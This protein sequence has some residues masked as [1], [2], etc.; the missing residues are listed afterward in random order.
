METLI[1]VILAFAAL[2][3]FTLGVIGIESNKEINEHL[4][5]VIN[6]VNV[7]GKILLVPVILVNIFRVIGAKI[8]MF[9]RSYVKRILTKEK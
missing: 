5:K 3:H 1:M 7:V 2:G 8:P 9:I 4:S 6:S